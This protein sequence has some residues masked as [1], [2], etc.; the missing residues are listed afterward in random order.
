LFKLEGGQ[1][2][3]KKEKLHLFEVQELRQL[4]QAM[5]ASTEEMQKLQ[6]TSHQESPANMRTEGL[7]IDKEEFKD[8]IRFS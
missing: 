2:G 6:D 1:A 5:E 4:K 3:C 8:F 7:Y